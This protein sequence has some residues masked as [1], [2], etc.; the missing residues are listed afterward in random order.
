MEHP[1]DHPRY[2]TRGYNNQVRFNSYWTQ[3]D[4]VLDCRPESVLEIGVGSGLVSWYLR[5]IGVTVLTLDV[6]GRLGPD[7]VGSVLDMPFEDGGFDTVACFE[8]LEH[9]PLEDLPGALTEIGRVSSRC[10]VISLP[11]TRPRLR[12]LLGVPRLPEFTWASSLR[13]PFSR[14]SSHDGEHH[15]EIGKNGVNAREVRRTMEENGFVLEKDFI[16]FHVPSQH[17]FCLRKA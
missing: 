11:D 13:R 12:L 6:D 5:R 14:S 8:V 10:A 2:L 4:C 1:T 16:P 3:I 15:W 9:L 17:F 7:I